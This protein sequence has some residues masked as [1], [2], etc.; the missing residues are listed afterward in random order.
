MAK[1][2]ENPITD[3]IAAFLKYIGISVTRGIVPD[4]A[5][6]PGILVRNGGLI[7][8]E[9][10]LLYPGDLLHEAGHLAFAP[11]AIRRSLSGEVVLPGVVSDVIEVQ[12]ILWSYA[13]AVHLRIQPEIVF[14]EDGYR[15]RSKR[16]LFNFS[17]G[18]FIGLP[19]MEREGMAYSLNRA[20]ELGVAPFPAMQKWL[21]D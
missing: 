21:V 9:S 15:G 5:F 14:H 6:L 17:I 13:A 4:D 12:A 11:S 8:D 7:V 3:K 20:A 16:I 18:N 2:Y 10:K 19:G 1:P